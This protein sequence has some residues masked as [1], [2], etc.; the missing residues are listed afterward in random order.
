MTG[1]AE[2]RNP[3]VLWAQRKDCVY[4]TVAVEDC[5]NAQ[6]KIESDKVIF[7]GTGGDKHTYECTLTLYGKLKVDE[8]K[9]VTR[10]RATEMLLVKES[11]GEYWPRLLKDTTKM[12]WLKVDFNKWKDEDDSDAED[13]SGG[14]FEEMMRQIGGF[15]GPD[16]AGGDFDDEVD[17]D[18]EGLPDLEPTK[19]DNIVESKDTKE[20]EEKKE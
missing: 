18:D 12:H 19:A 3:V 16:A 14:N 13:M 15:G 10:D 8:S 1:T 6:V 9:F 5:K 2:V 17:S 7:K 4:L 20:D 11:K